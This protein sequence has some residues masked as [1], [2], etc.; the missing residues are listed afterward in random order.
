LLHKAGGVAN[1]SDVVAVGLDGEIVKINSAEDDASIRRSGQQTEVRVNTR[2][3]TH[4]L[5]FDCAV[6]CGLKHRVA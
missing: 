1:A 2:V 6:D 5:S 4:T 3:K